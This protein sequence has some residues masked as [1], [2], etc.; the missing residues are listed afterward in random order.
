MSPKQG[1]GLLSTVPQRL[2]CLRYHNKQDMLP[3]ISTN[4]SIT[5]DVFPNIS[6]HDGIRIDVFPSICTNDGIRKDNTVSK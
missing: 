3:N 5:I 1:G 4:D 2:M 6:T